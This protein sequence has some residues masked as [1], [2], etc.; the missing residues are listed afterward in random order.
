MFVHTL[1]EF[2]TSLK[3]S[4]FFSPGHLSWKLH[5]SNKR[6]LTSATLVI[7]LQ[8]LYAKQ[9]EHTCWTANWTG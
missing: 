9:T 2:F 7:S 1:Y 6:N 4:N 3:S 8:T 5:F